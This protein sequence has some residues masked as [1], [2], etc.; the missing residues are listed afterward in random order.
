[1]LLLCLVSE[2]RKCNYLAGVVVD[3]E[4]GFV[5]LGRLGEVLVLGKVGVQLV[6]VG[7]VSRL[8][9]STQRR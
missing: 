8:S 9:H 7:L 6:H 1:M 4:D 2:R 3:G 5:G